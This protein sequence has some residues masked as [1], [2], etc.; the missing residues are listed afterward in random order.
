MNFE[1]NEDQRQLNESILRMLK[2]N[3]RFDQR[4]QIVVSEPGWSPKTWRLLSQLGVTGIGI[5]EVWGGLGG[6]VSD[7]MPVMQAFGNALSVE[8]LLASVVLGTT[9]LRE[10]GSDLQRKTI[11]PSLADGSARVAWAHD[12]LDSRH[13][14]L[15]VQT[16]ARQID[17]LWQL[18]GTKSLV[19]HAESAHYLIVTARI[20]GKANEPEGLGLFLVDSKISNL[21][22]RCYRLVDDTPAADV[23]FND[24]AAE[25]LGSFEHKGEAFS[26]IRQT[27]AA[28]TAGAC[29]DMIG[30][31]EGAFELTKDYVNTRIQFNRTIGENQSVRHRIAEMAVALEMARSMAIAAV[32]AVDDQTSPGAENDLLRAKF[33]VGRNAISLCENAIQLH[34]GI[35]MT[36]D[37]AVGH[38]LRRVQ[39]LDQLFGDY[40]TQNKRL[41][42]NFAY[43]VTASFSILNEN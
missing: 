7:L 10:A 28:G 34:G 41:A 36:E 19:I 31:M 39:V 33:V 30:C 12:E 3:Y 20:Y 2:D 42:S 37:Y 6:G 22:K 32:V 14:N 18:T 4:R 8:P 23:Y 5:P 11:L 43:D 25:L 35:G 40:Q 13:A 16:A 21:R 24:T 27:L 29:A 17:N 9:A 26:A 1:L 15:W 38:Y